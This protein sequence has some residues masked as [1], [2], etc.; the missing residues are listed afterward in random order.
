MQMLPGERVLMETNGRILMLTSHRI[1]YGWE[2]KS[3]SDMISMLLE[4]VD[5][6]MVTHHDNT[7]MLVWAVVLLFVGFIVAAM[8][9][10][11]NYGLM[12]PGLLIGFVGFVLLLMYFMTRYIYLD[13][14][15]VGGRRIRLQMTRTMVESIRAFVDQVELAKDARYQSLRMEANR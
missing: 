15:S 12:I 10:G 4:Q 13:I 9:S 3:D 5:S 6:C 2:T 7:S 11:G 8:N 14:L 1:R